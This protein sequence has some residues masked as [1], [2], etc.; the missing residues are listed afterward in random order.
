MTDGVQVRCECA[1]RGEGF[2]ILTSHL[3][4]VGAEDAGS[5]GG[6]QVIS[7][8]QNHDGAGQSSQHGRV[9]VVDESVKGEE[10]TLYQHV[11]IRHLT[12]Q[13]T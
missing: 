9:Q 8:T 4:F 3:P 2:F 11:F 10:R 13:H 5:E 6:N 12:T 1:F 7:Q